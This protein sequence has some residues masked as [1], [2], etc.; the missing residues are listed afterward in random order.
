MDFNDVLYL[1]VLIFSVCFGKY[2]T[3]ITDVDKKQRVCTL[4][5]FCIVLVT[6]RTQC[7]YSIGLVAVNAFIILKIRRFSLVLTFV[8]SFVLLILLRYYQCLSGHSNLIQMMLTLKLIGLS[9]EL[10]DNQQLLSEINSCHRDLDTAENL[11]YLLLPHSEISLINIV[12]YCFCYVGVLTGP[13]YKYQT[14][15]DLFN[16]RINQSSHSNILAVF[17]RLKYLPF[18]VT[19]FLC[20]SYFYS[21][22]YVLDDSFYSAHTC[23][24]RWWYSLPVFFTF[25]FR[26]YIGLLLSE[27]VAIMVGLGAYPGFTDSRPGQGP[28]ANVIAFRKIALG[29]SE[30]QPCQ[31]DCIDFNTVYSIHIGGVETEPTLKR[32]IKLWNTTVQYWMYQNVYRRVTERKLRIPLVFFIS[33]LWHGLHSGYYLSICYMPVYLYIE[34][35]YANKLR[36]LFHNKTWPSCL[37][38]LLFV[39]KTV[40]SSSLCMCFVLLNLSSIGRYFVSIYFLPFLLH[41]VIYL[42]GKYVASQTVKTSPYRLTNNN[43]SLCLKKTS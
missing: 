40:T 28:T 6:A 10:H 1:L 7:V 37:N 29:E 42:G 2:V 30:F 13:Y 32:T 5:G 3:Q 25:K 31:R 8:F 33:A 41:A 27:A 21:V 22:Q 4:A 38:A 19:V 11:Q 18:Y 24:Y 20:L 23:L 9:Y 39:S 36:N 14:Y 35:L 17:T 43:N 15:L 12:H 16:P 34:D 26:L